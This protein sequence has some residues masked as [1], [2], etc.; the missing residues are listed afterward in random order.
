MNDLHKTIFNSVLTNI[1]K[2]I[3]E[4][5]ETINNIKKNVNK[6]SHV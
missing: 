5:S 6:D 3:N 4:E 1:Q 2:I